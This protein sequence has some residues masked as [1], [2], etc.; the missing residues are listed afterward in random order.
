MSFDRYKKD[1]EKLI[2][3]GEMLY[4]AML[5]EV[6]PQY[7]KELKFKKEVLEK[8][9]TFSDQY[10]SWYAES[11]TCI[12][13]LLPERLEDFISYYKPL[14][15]RKEI[16]HENYTVS[17]YLKGLSITVGIQK[18]KIVGPD[19]SLPAFRQQVNIAKSLQKRFESSLFDIQT[20]VQADLFD[21]ELDAAEELNKKGFHRGAGALAGVVLEGHL[22]TICKLHKITA[23]KRA[24]LGKLNDLL[25]E[26]NVLDVPT[27][28]FIQRLVDL[29]NLC[30]H[31]MAKEP[32][33][34]DI[35]ELVGG[36]RK[37]TKT[38]L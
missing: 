6:R 16:T 30:D 32:T 38:M 8:L 4:I 3:D 34:E 15:V 21:N 31:K 35:D 17:D 18:Q 12:S 22:R 37:V 9:P 2:T 24:M 10:Q 33:K 19:S 23:P 26:K 27:W 11:V 7:K 13:Q 20:L 28:R 1:I 29:R 25:K 36:V 14:R 5:I